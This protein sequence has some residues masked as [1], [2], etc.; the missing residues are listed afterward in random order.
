M[1]NYVDRLS[2]IALKIFILKAAL[3]LENQRLAP[4]PR[5]RGG[6]EI[7]FMEFN[8]TIHIGTAI[9]ISTLKMHSN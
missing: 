1:A 4:G 3:A 7:H 5:T 8:N 6:F 9:I 2:L